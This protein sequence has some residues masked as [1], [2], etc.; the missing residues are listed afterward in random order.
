MTNIS[1]ILCT[2]NRCE[3]LV[4]ALDSLS[5]SILPE[6]V[7]WE[8]LVVD[9][10]SSDST[11][12]VAER[13][14]EKQPT[15]FRYIFE[16]KPGKSNALNKGVEEAT[17]QIL[18]FTDDDLTVEPT[19]LQNL[20][21]HLCS[22]EWAG[23]GG[24]V[25]PERD[26]SPPRWIPLSDKRAL[27]PLSVFDRGPE[28]GPLDESPI[29]ASMAFHRRMFEKYGGFRTDIGPGL[30]V[31]SLQKSEDNEFGRRLRAAGEKLRYEPASLAYHPV[32]QYRLNKRYFLKWWFEKTGSDILAF[33]IPSDRRYIAGVPL[34]LVTRLA[35]WTMRW[36]VT[37]GP[38]QRFACKINVWMLAGAILESYRQSRVKEANVRP[39]ESEF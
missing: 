35:V 18:A 2:H 25:L 38:S 39:S 23:A 6:C 13:F 5:A 4:K 10:N 24:R 22:G 29:G 14:C 33:G 19:W 1:V 9:N 8:V 12:Q 16:P 15:H 27:A 26:F 17:G 3:S 11:R 32:P 30:G 34:R 31:G 7:E 36:V 28:P 37:I 21:A 20:T